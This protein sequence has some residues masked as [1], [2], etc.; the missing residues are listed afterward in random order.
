MK[1]AMIQIAV[2][3]NARVRVNIPEDGDPEEQVTVGI[4]EGSDRLHAVPTILQSEGMDD[5]EKL[6]AS[7]LALHQTMKYATQEVEKA[8]EKMGANED[9]GSI[10]TAPEAQA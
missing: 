5:K 3:V 1:T 7:Q 2:M 4:F 8:T 10:I 9:K 6:V